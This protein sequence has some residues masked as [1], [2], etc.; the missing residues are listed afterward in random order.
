MSLSK[1]ET[2][3]QEYGFVYLRDN[4]WF[5]IEKV[6]KLGISAILKDRGCGYITGE[7]IPGTFI[8]GFKI[9]LQDMHKLDRLMKNY[10]KPYHKYVLGGGTEFYDR[11]IID[12]VEHYLKLLRV[13]YTL[14]S[15]EEINK[16]ERVE[17]LKKLKE[18]I[19][20]K[21]ALQKFAETIR[22]K[23]CKIHQWKERDY[24]ISTI[25]MAL[26]I[27]HRE[28]KIYIEL[29]TGGGKSYI[30]YN[31][32]QKL[33]SNFILILSP[34]KIVNSQNISDKYLQILK[35][36]YSILNYSEN[37]NIDE[38]LLKK[39]KKILI[40]CTQT[41]KKIY[42]KL[43]SS[44]I[45]NIDVWFDEAH[46]GIEGWTREL[47][48]EP[49][50]RF[51]LL[52]K[53]N[54]RNRIFTSASPDKKIVQENKSI[55]GILYSPVKIKQLID[56]KWLASIKPYVYENRVKT[57]I[58]RASYILY[59]FKEKNRNYG[60]SF[61]HNQ[62]NAYELFHQHYL[63]YKSGITCI[64]PFLLIGDDFKREKEQ[65]LEEIEHCLGYD[66]RNVVEFEKMPNNM[67]YVVQKY[68]MGY[69]FIKLDYL[70][71]SDPKVSIQDI[72]QCIG[73]GIRSDGLGENGSN[74]EKELIIALH[75]SKNGIE[76]ETNPYEKIFQVL[77]YLIH[78]IEITFDDIGVFSYSP[79]STSDEKPYFI[80]YSGSE[81][82]KS[83]F[84]DLLDSY[85]R[86]ISLGTTYEA[87]KII[88]KD[89][90]LQSKEEYYKL[91]EID[92]RLSLDP[93]NIYKKE[94]L[95]NNWYDF[96]GIDTTKF[97]QSKQEWINFC[98]E[99]NIKKLE[100]YFIA[101]NMYNNL[102]K[103]P[104]DYYKD[105]TNITSE[106]KFYNSRRR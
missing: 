4:K 11:C 51:C 57:S 106:L 74:K 79:S 66:Y 47:L 38:F 65:I 62:N 1:F 36:K 56:M 95:W 73:R 101:C 87:A 6:I 17:R 35:D 77:K 94:G 24:Q 78:D 76:E 82:M 61:H 37:N 60:F 20:L 15:E 29:P 21:K 67:G 54:I 34:R 12:T 104:A 40:C 14:L 27:I 55:F 49:H 42:E 2:T 22:N 31:I 84:L 88:I 81:E 96:L 64:K 13:N 97:I 26:E 105:F 39:G 18:S 25:N 16:M 86:N 71:F 50:V 32:F 70:S 92:K 91:C 72:I 85:N 10:F 52:N 100:D 23:K 19:T 83:V 44:N 43:I 90:N 9:P 28:N 98:K 102:P 53:N 69:D 7:P 48:E 80:D 5:Q 99:K 46:Y 8:K 59:D 63:K 75:T 103:E 58:D 45:N 93:E 33:E 89:Q 68:N 41:I 30:V 3:Q